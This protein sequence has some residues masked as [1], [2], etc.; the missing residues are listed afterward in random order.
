[1][2]LISAR[3]LRAIAERRLTCAPLDCAGEADC[4][5][6][7]EAL[8]QLLPDEVDAAPVVVPDEVADYAPDWSAA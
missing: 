7:A 2:K 8:L 1:M 4:F 3:E 5:R 6:L